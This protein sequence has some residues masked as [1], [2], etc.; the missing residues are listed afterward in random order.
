[1]SLESLIAQYETDLNDAKEQYSVLESVARCEHTCQECIAR[2][3][4][5]ESQRTIL[6]VYINEKSKAIEE[7]K[8]V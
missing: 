4:E 2:L 8:N 6:S 7:L 1:M 5:N 3:A